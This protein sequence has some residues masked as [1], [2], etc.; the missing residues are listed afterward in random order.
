MTVVIDT[1]IT[2]NEAGLSTAP[3]KLNLRQSLDGLLR[4]HRDSRLISRSSQVFPSF[5]DTKFSLP[6]KSDPGEARVLSV[7]PVL[8]TLYEKSELSRRLSVV[9]LKW[10][11]TGRLSNCT[12]MNQIHTEIASRNLLSLPH[13]NLN[14]EKSLGSLPKLDKE[15]NQLAKGVLSSRDDKFRTFFISLYSGRKRSKFS[16]LFTSGRILKQ[17]FSRLR[18][19]MHYLDRKSYS[20]SVDRYQTNIFSNFR[21]YKTPR[22]ILS[23]LYTVLGSSEG[24]H[25]QCSESRDYIGC[26]NS[27]L[28]GK[29]FN[30]R[31]WFFCLLPKLIHQGFR[32]LSPNHAQ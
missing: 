10:N 2:K 16:D 29:Q 15:P 20:W 4:R 19:V 1:T 13:L 9:C 14:N 24:I 3:S 8:G 32:N 5:S 23:E 21:F 22:R 30:R 31:H 6:P 18:I 11:A 12:I 27:F 7:L 25:R 28:H 26:R 17:G